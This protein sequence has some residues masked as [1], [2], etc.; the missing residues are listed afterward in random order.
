MPID[1]DVLVRGNL[2]KEWELELEPIE[3]SKRPISTP[4]EFHIGG[5]DPAKVGKAIGELDLELDTQGKEKGSPLSR[6]G[7]FA[8]DHRGR[9]LRCKIA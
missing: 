1:S 6:N 5:Q 7:M 9:W 8:S 3:H 4:N 2:E